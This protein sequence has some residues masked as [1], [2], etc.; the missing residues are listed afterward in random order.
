MDKIKI[1]ESLDSW[2]PIIDGPGSV[3]TNYAKHLNNGDECKLI[4][5]RAKEKDYVDNHS[6]EVFRCAAVSAPDNYRCAF[7]GADRR[8]KAYLKTQKFDIYH[9]HSPFNLGAYM[10]R[11]GKKNGV[12]VVAHLHTKY[13]QDFDRIPI[14]KMFKRF[15]MRRIMKTYKNADSVWTVNDATADVLRGYGYTGNIEVVRNGTDMVYPDNAGAL[16]KAVNEK[17]GLDGAENVLL[18]VGRI[19]W[20]KNLGLICSALKYAKSKGLK[21]KMLVVG[22]GEDEKKF[23]AA[24]AE[25]GLQD[26]F[27]FA[28]KITDRKFLSGYYLRSDLFLFPSTFDTSSLVPVEAAAHCLPTLLIEG[29]ST[30]ENI[31]RDETGFLAPETPEGYGQ[32]IYDICADKPLLKLVGENA[33]KRVY[34]SWAD[35]VAEVRQKY[36]EVICQYKEKQ[37]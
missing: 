15:M 8:L 33:H 25:C 14:A 28:G 32:K 22:F 13:D 9:V 24:A 36:R 23:K 30:A 7:P 26:D 11:A 17:H 34:R 2:L 10:V 16:I 4:V 37:K 12:P 27:I 31:V 35:V 18:F 6:F 19:V 20:Y 5:P 21:F 1:A 29:C 3:V